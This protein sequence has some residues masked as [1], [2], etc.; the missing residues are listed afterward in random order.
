MT[1]SLLNDL[2]R[3]DLRIC[4]IGSVDRAAILDYRS[5]HHHRPIVQQSTDDVRW[6]LIQHCWEWAVDRLVQISVVINCPSTA[7]RCQSSPQIRLRQHRPI[8]T[9]T[10]DR[11]R[12]QHDPS[13]AQT[14]STPLVT[15]TLKYYPME[16]LTLHRRVGRGRRWLYTD[17]LECPWVL[18]TTD[19]K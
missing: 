7:Q 18:Q 1:S 6:Q 14:P 9:R 16:T 4:A 10:S 8:V 12:A 19:D 5:S 15:P 13:I 3:C 2:K 11:P 17:D